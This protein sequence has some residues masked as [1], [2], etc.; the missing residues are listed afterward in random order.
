M[1]LSLF[2][3]SLFIFSFF[4]TPVKIIAAAAVLCAFGVCL[5]CRFY[6]FKNSKAAHK[7]FIPFLFL[8]SVALALIVSYSSF[9]LKYGKQI[10]EI[11]G[12]C[13]S[14]IVITGSNGRSEKSASYH[15][16]IIDCNGKEC[17]I[18]AIFTTDFDSDFKRSDLISADVIIVPSFNG[19]SLAEK[20]HLA[21]G[22][23]CF[24]S[25]SSAD[26]VKDFG[27]Q[28]VFPYTQISTLR[29][30]CS[31][32]LDKYLDGQALAQ[33]KAIIYGDKSSLS[34]TTLSAFAN[35]GI[36]HTLAI[37]GLHMGIIITFLTFFLSIFRIPRK[38][39]HAIILLAG[40][41]YIF[42]AG[43]AP[44]VCRT[45]IMFAIMIASEFSRRKRD[46]ATTLVMA[47]FSIC[48]MSPASILDIGLHLSFFSTL[49]ILTYALPVMEKINDSISQKP[50]RH[51][52]SM[53]TITLC[54]TVFTL[55]YNTFVF[56]QISI[57]SPIANIIYIPIITLMVYLS[58]LIIIFSFV[59]F[60]PV[61]IS[62]AAKILSFVL[63]YLT[64]GIYRASSCFLLPLDTYF[65]QIS[66]VIFCVSAVIMIFLGV[67]KRKVLGSFGL[68]IFANIL[69]LGIS[70]F[71]L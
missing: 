62:Y 17:R 11:S 28:S 58:V 48:I 36:S 32:A 35:L 39:R 13:E 18:P 4:F 12:Q 65:G 1:Y 2:L 54:A 49:G 69:S 64:E 16:V 5:L 50:V 24:A 52:L 42:I 6:L 33:S 51:I 20:S 9:D 71:L 40:L 34:D 19:N 37:S 63:S 60:V 22:I 61:I 23:L 44:S 57:I 56:G 47:L 66:T 46:N 70:R 15:A 43:L 55:P 59:P 27:K 53:C 41:V 7:A 38:V 8:T 14:K 31:G 29:S 3:I 25:C 30:Y 45:Y 21:K 26:T 10:Q 67:K 68:F